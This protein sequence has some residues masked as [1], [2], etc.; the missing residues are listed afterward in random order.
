MAEIVLAVTKDGAVKLPARVRAKYGLRTGDSIRLV[1][2]GGNFVLI[3]LTPSVAK[4]AQSIE[5]ARRKAGVSMDEMF[6]GLRKQRKRYYQE[7]FKR[8]K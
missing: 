1:D 2:V 4:L 6:K 8:A 7:K 3:P 5:H